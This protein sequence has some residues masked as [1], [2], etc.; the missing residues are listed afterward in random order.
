M[1]KFNS[2]KLR[3]QPNFDKW[4][5]EKL[6]KYN[7]DVEYYLYMLFYDIQKYLLIIDEHRLQYKN[8]KITLTQY[9]E[10]NR[11]VRKIEW[12]YHENLVL[13]VSRWDYYIENYSASR[14]DIIKD[15]NKYIRWGEVKET[16]SKPN[17]HFYCYG[18]WAL[19]INLIRQF[20]LEKVKK[21][22][23]EKHYDE[24]EKK[25]IS[26]LQRIKNRICQD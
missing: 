15:I 18:E 26:L 23:V 2:N 11:V 25:R 24:N 8:H 16:H 6:N 19:D 17:I 5:L 3:Y 12:Y 4:S 1:F 21:Y 22:E 20:C 9:I 14:S 13:D 7:N 10:S